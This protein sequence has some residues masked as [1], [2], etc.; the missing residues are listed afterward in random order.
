MGT[1]ASIKTTL[2]ANDS[3]PWVMIGQSIEGLNKLRESSGGPSG[4]KNLK[5]YKS[6]KSGKSGDGSKTDEKNAIDLILN[7]STSDI[8]VWN[9]IPDQ[10][11][12]ANGNQVTILN[13]TNSSKNNLNPNVATRFQ[14]TPDGN[15]TGACAAAQGTAGYTNAV[16]MN[17][18]SNNQSPTTCTT[19]QGWTQCTS[20]AS[21]GSQGAC[22]QGQTC[23][24]GRCIN[25]S[26][27]GFAGNYLQIGSWTIFPENVGT[28]NCL[29]FTTN[30]G[31]R[32][33]FRMYDT[34]TVSSVCAANTSQTNQGLFIYYFP[35]GP[36][37]AAASNIE[38]N[39]VGL[40]CSKPP[41]AQCASND[42]CSS[43][44]LGNVC[45]GGTCY[46][47]GTQAR[48]VSTLNIGS[49]TISEALNSNGA[50][51]EL[52]FTSPEGNYWSMQD[53]GNFL[54][55][56]SNG[57]IRGSFQWSPELWSNNSPTAFVSG[58]SFSC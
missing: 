14:M 8:N 53:S 47:L 33:R 6:G 24:L 58:N 22:A 28:Q 19:Q 26:T 44:Q 31:M 56:C 18:I 30:L 21:S 36:S 2:S 34:G 12:D 57:N 48:S 46:Q 17:T 35:G 25:S 39:Y 52:R 55:V 27:G 37:V 10:V 54:S 16:D 49:W 4:P 40:P 15:F 51:S 32:G 42:N 45:I 3:V 13:F 43:N 1:T 20:S 11:P 38:P 7:G 5:T 50:A 29:S 41:I 9:I 23:V